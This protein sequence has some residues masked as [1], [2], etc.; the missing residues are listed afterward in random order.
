VKEN[1]R[2]YVCAQKQIEI[3]PM[4]ENQGL[5]VVA[6]DPGVRTFA[7]SYSG[8]KVTKYGE[9]F[10]EK[11]VFPL[12]L[13]LDKLI[14]D[15]AK[16]RHDE[17]KRGI[18]KKIDRLRSKISDLVSDLHKRVA[19]DLVSNY[20]VILLPNFETKQMSKKIGRKIRTKTVRS[21]LGLR[22]YQFKQHL[23]WMARK[24]GKLVVDVNEA[25]TSKTRSW[26]GVIDQKLGGKDIITDGKVVVDRDINGA[27][28]ILLRA[29]YGT[30]P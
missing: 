25:Y 18:Q 11:R 19:H 3:T 16:S 21:M 10:F 17:W 20:D 4:T 9:N 23:K 15:R 1:G 24:N 14:S 26:D 8:T 22:H 13:R 29:L 7:T 30:C 27:R 12:L 5:D 28:G 6:I 2:W